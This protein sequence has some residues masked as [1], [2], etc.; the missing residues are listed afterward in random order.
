MEKRNKIFRRP[1]FA[2]A[3]VIMVVLMSVYAASLLIPLAWTFL[4]SLK[5]Q[6]EFSTYNVNG[7][8][9]R[10]L[11]GNYRDAFTV[12]NIDGSNY[13]IMLFNS[14]WYAAG[15]AFI[16]VAVSSMVA[17]V[18]AK[19]KF[20]GAKFIHSLAIVMMIIPIVGSLPSQFRVIKGLGILD[21]PFFLVTAAGGFGFNFLILY[22]YFKSLPWS[23]A[24]AAFIDGAGHARVYL[25]V[26][27]PQAVPLLSAIGIMALITGW[28]DYTNPLL[29]LKSYP[30][31]ASGLYMFQVITTRE[32][33]MPV[34]YAGLLLSAVPILILFIFFSNKIMTISI[35]GGLKG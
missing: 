14:I 21:T 4:T 22:A 19:Y 11:F 28:N 5:S 25:T 23:F 9:T 10:W 8:P 34:L 31:L 24:E 15:G 27:M 12:L 3:K 16:G 35:G 13:F 26:M 29:F 7:L 17:Y 2:A 1:G 18:V 6:V 32:L 20:P 30:T 33:N